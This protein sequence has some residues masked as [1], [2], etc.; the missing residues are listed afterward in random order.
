MRIL[1][2]DITR[3]ADGFVC[4]A[5]IDLETDKRV[6]P[7]LTSRLPAE[8]VSSRGGKFDIRRIVDLGACVPAGAPPE[9]EDMH[10][11]LAACKHVDTIVGGSFFSHLRTVALNGLSAFG[12]DLVAAGHN[13]RALPE[14]VG[15]RSL[16]IARATERFDVSINARGS[17]RARWPDGLDLSVTDIRL[18][19]D[20][21]RTA[22][23]MKV[24]WL[25][26]RLA[27][28][29]EIY[30]C[31]GLGRPFQAAGDDRRRHWLQLNNIHLSSTPDWQL[32]W[33]RE[34]YI[35]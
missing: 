3:M 23:G 30:L 17:V 11:A 10:F 35:S 4:V 34:R 28:D 8:L 33:P 19:Q 26:R 7:V 18:Y 32:R 15:M 6:R 22:D 27:H 1:V 13:G 25:R 14:G 21:F 9:T 5:G 31:Y 29:P 20:D 24:E 16:V 2:T 12:P